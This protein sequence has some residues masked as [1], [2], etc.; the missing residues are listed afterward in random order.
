VI[1]SNSYNFSLLHLIHLIPVPVVIFIY[2]TLPMSRGTK[3]CLKGLSHKLA[4]SGML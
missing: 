4:E 3:L 2:F 1:L